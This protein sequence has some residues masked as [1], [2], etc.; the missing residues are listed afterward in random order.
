MIDLRKSQ[1]CMRKGCG[2]VGLIW[3]K[4][5]NATPIPLISSDRICG[6][7]IKSPSSGT[8]DITIITVYLPCSDMGMECYSEHLIEL[9]RVVLS[10]STIALQICR[11]QSR[12]VGPPYFR[13]SAFIPSCP[14][15][16]PSFS[17]FKTLSTSSAT[18]GTSNR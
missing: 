13:C 10:A 11:T 18:N 6:I 4:E 1:L 8:D 16:L 14:A 17:F 7:C 2:G 3:K 12:S 5:I 15:A 9:E